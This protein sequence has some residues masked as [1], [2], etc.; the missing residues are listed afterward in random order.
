MELSQICSKT[1]I[2]RISRQTVLISSYCGSPPNGL[3]T[4]NFDLKYIATINELGLLFI[5]NAW[6][7]IVSVH[8]L[9]YMCINHDP[10]QFHVC[11][12]ERVWAWVC[13]WL[14]P[15]LFQSLSSF[16][17]TQLMVRIIY[18]VEIHF[19]CQMRVHRSILLEYSKCIAKLFEIETSS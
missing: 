14:F 8:I 13:V 7:E 12:C 17:S 9:K 2:S 19:I 18:T 3:Q 4:N 16:E 1:S 6:C 15:R 11:V 5:N 10:Y